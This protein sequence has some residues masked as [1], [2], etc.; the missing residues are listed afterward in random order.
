MGS[1]NIV[2]IT[3]EPLGAYHIAPM[4]EEMSSRFFKFTHLIPYP[5]AL[6]GEP[7][8][9]I[10]SSLSILD[11][12][13]RVI[14]AGGGF[15]AWSESV[16][17]YASSLGKPIYL[18]E[19]SYGS[20]VSKPKF[21]NINKVSALTPANKI[22]ICKTL[23]ISPEKVVVTGSPQ[24][25]PNMEHIGDL[26]LLLSTSDMLIRDSSANL[27]EVA[28]YLQKN[29]IPYLI[30]CHPREDKSPWKGHPLSCSPLLGEDLSLAKIVV[31]YTGSPSL[32][33]VAS[34]IPLINLAPNDNFTN[35]LP[36]TYKSILPNWASNYED[37]IILLDEFSLP[38]TESIEA[39]LGNNNQAARQ[40]V[41][42][43]VSE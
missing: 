37:V 30:R 38:N 10:S 4:Y 1:K 5:E 11:S 31:A 13:D 20:F 15:S 40:I 2:I 3:S 39:L 9:N 24:I 34:G 27:I 8:V 35:I 23:P 14:L 19:L 26:V 36:N 43:W 41:D 6:Q 12:C 22:L 21:I 25:I 18:T 28:N 32:N 33:V 17:S 16:L 29:K 42:F 7:W